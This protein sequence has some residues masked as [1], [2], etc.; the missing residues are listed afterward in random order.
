[1]ISECGSLARGGPF[2]VWGLAGA[3][4]NAGHG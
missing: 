3:E 1:M 2:G 4:E